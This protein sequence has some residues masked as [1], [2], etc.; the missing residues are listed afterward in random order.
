MTQKLCEHLGW[1]HTRVEVGALIR[2]YAH[3]TG[4]CHTLIGVTG[5]FRFII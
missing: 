3:T 2:V 5:V 1:T 4:W